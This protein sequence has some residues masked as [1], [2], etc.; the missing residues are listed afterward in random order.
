M[1]NPP[2]D[3]RMSKLTIQPRRFLSCDL[4]G[5][6]QPLHLASRV[7]HSQSHLSDTSHTLQVPSQLSN[8]PEPEYQSHA[9]SHVIW[10]RARFCGLQLRNSMTSLVPNSIAA[11]SHLF[12]Q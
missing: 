9:A 4:E 10:P 6:Y 3:P 5:V 8:T 12:D 7:L 11:P 1:R 2:E